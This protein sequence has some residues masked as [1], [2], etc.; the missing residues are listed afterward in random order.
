MKA[1]N[2]LPLLVRNLA[3]RSAS[4][5]IAGHQLEARRRLSGQVGTVIMPGN[6]LDVFMV[7][8]TIFIGVFNAKVRQGELAVH[9]F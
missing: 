7:T 3:S 6:Y 5:S 8:F 9:N 2:S 1:L 4:R